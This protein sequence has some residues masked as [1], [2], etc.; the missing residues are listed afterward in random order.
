MIKYI[1][2]RYGELEPVEQKGYTNDFCSLHQPPAKKGFYAFPHDKVEMYLINPVIDGSV[3]SYAHYVKDKYGKPIVGTWNM[4]N[5]SAL[6]I[7]N[8]SK[9]YDKISSSKVIYQSK[10]GIY[11]L[12]K[13]KNYDEIAYRNDSNY[14]YDFIEENFLGMY[15]L[16]LDEPKRFEHGGDIWCHLHL[17]CNVESSDIIESKHQWIKLSMKNYLKYLKIVNDAKE[18]EYKK[19]GFHKSKDLYEVFIEFIE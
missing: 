5:E 10:E 8:E 1:F 3:A 14:D 2:L 6:E 17:H 16:E 9:E 11:T 19:N 13:W 18:E 4:W 15:F 7:F 12:A